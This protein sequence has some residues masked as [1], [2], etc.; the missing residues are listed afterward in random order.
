MRCDV[1]R[2][3]ACGEAICTGPAAEGGLK[4]PGVSGEGLDG[5]GWGSTND[6]G[7]VS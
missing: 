6:G 1:G 3:G 2:S 7:G 5:G 4:R